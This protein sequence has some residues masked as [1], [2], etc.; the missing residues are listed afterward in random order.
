LKLFYINSP[1]KALRAILGWPI[2]AAGL[3]FV[4][5]LLGGLI[6]VNGDWTEPAKGT[7][8]YLSDNG[9]HTSIII[10]CAP[11]EG[12]DTCLFPASDIANTHFQA[13]WQ[14]IGWGDREF[15]LN[16]PTWADLNLRTAATAFLGSGKT[17]VHVDH[18]DHLPIDGTKALKVNDAELNA[19]LLH[20][21][22]SAGIETFA[23]LSSKP[24]KGYGQNDVFY[25][26]NNAGSSSYSMLF[27][28]NNWVSEILAS[29]GVKTGFWT[30]LPFGVMWWH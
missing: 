18:L 10:P 3:Y 7:T 16:T 28:C 14:M 25:E 9:I 8:I 23:S 19:I 17:L 29:A 26:A 6:P 12:A 13:R 20:I 5:A 1:W 4:A 27:T 22:H 24:I 11:G 30:P 2:L 21:R 15:Y